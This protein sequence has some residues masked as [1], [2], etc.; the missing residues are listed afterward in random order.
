MI[1]AL[2]AVNV[3]VTH[4]NICEDIA[5]VLETNDHP[6]SALAEVE[7]SQNGPLM[8]RASLSNT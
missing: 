7:K 8:S 4:I 3:L 5:E 2:E 6:V 1:S